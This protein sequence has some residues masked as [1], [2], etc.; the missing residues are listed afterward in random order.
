MAAALGEDRH[1]TADPALFRFLSHNTW[2]RSF[3]FLYQGD[4][5]ALC[6]DLRKKA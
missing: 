5:T 3:G 1:R 4:L 2:N 6:A